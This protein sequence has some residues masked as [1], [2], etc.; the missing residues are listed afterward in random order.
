MFNL[1]KAVRAASER[2]KERQ[3][4]LTEELNINTNLLDPNS[5][6]AKLSRAREQEKDILTQIDNLKWV[7]GQL[8][9]TRLSQLLERLSELL[10]EQGKFSEASKVAVS[11]ERRKYYKSLVKAAEIP[12]DTVCDCQPE[13][14]MDSVKKRELS[15]PTEQVLAEVYSEKH[16]EMKNLVKCVK[17]GLLN[18]K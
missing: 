3:E 4:E 8:K 17:C 10:A 5:K 18:I 11:D 2:N 14:I 13:K 15:V 16:G 1:D 7:R 6:E 12:D 9:Q